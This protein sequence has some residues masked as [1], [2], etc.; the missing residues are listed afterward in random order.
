MQEHAE[1]AGTVRLC[2]TIGRKDH[3]KVEDIVKSIITESR[4][5]FKKIGKI[6]ILDKFTFVEVPLEF[7]ERI[8]RSMNDIVMKGRR[9]KIKRAGAARE[10][11]Y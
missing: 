1:D 10:K 6:D 3:I 8:I 4:V 2:M 9:V 5:P 11:D 7:S